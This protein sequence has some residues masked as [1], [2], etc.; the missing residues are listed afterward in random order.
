MLNHPVG[1]CPPWLR[2]G[3]A[4]RGAFS[5]ELR[6]DVTCAV[7]ADLSA[8]VVAKVYR[9]GDFA[10]AHIE[11]AT[12]TAAAAAGV[13]TPALLGVQ[14]SDDHAVTWWRW[15]EGAATSDPLDV[16]GLLRVLHDRAN[17]DGLPA[18][19]QAPPR[20]VLADP[21]ARALA[22]A[23][24]PMIAA[25]GA[26]AAR[27]RDLPVVVVHGDPN[28]TNVLVGAGGLVLLDFGSGGPG[29]RVLDVTAAVVLAVECGSATP[30]QVLAAYGAHPD[31][32]RQALADAELVVAADRAGICY[33]IPGWLDEGWER[34]AA[35]RAGR[36]YVFGAGNHPK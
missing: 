30:V 8:A 2:A 15:R 16:V 3:F 26:A 1:H 11:A 22:V 19:A 20:P 33:T 18:C 35:W 5:P 21:G 6:R 25:A 32:T 34:H 36:R 9:P 27:L 14:V 17:P 12:A 29:P 4:A 10:R 7:W 23:L 13:D 24:A 31:V 28:P